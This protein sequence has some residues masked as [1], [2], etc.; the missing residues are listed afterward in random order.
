MM[1]ATGPFEVTMNPL[2][3]SAADPMLGRRS[4]AKVFRGDLEATGA[5]EMLTVGTDVQGSA[6]YVA[7]ERVTGTLQGRT[8][9]FALQHTGLMTR[10]APQLTIAIVPDSGT[11]ELAGIA[12]S[13]AI[14]VVEGQHHYD[15]DYTLPSQ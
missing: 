5:G 13:L 11:G 9:S 8:G 4:L 15:L 10:G 12:G 1:R 7:V 14:R 3:M 6:A 2:A